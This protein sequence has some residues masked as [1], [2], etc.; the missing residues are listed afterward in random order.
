MASV[1]NM[2]LAIEYLSGLLTSHS[3]MRSHL[4]RPP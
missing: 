4:K 1:C 3:L 2:Y